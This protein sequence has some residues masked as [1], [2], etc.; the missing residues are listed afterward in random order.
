MINPARLPLISVCICTYRRP[1]ML[2]RLLVELAK[3]QSGGNFTFEIVVTDNDDSGSGK[4]TTEAFAKMAAV[5]VRYG[6]E[7]RKNISFARNRCLKEARGDFIAFIDD[8]EFPA[9]GWLAHLHKTCMDRGVSGVLGPVRPHFD[10]PPP[11][12]ILKGRFCERPESPT[13]SELH[14]TQTRT[15]NVLFKT[16]IIAGL[17]EVFR[18]EFGAGSGDQDFFRRM[19]EQG[20]HFIWCNEAV[21]YEVVPP[22]RCTRRYLIERALL[23]GG[24]SLK[25][26]PPKERAKII[27]KSMV[28]APAYGLALPILHLG[29]HH[30]FMRY[31]VKFCDHAGRLLSLVGLNPV[32]QRGK[33]W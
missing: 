12:W 3:Q 11:Q 19:M 17:D 5:P 14:W 18:A 22:S 2:S 29:G 8:D 10:T 21:V 24:L 25:L 30:I 1:E 23:R 7:P 33:L 15:G 31:L 6:L 20:H 16:S 27:L 9:P 26:P 32:R 28:A 4:A 13:G